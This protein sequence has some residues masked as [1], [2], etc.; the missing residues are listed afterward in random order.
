MARRGDNEM[1]VNPF[2]DEAPPPAVAERD[3]LMG[4][5]ASAPAI[6]TMG[7]IGETTWRNFICRSSHPFAAFF[8][9]IFK[10]AAIVL[11]VCGSTLGLDYVTI[12]VCCVLL[13]AFDFWT[14]KNVTGR[15][16]VGLRWWIRIK[17]DGSNEWLFESA[18]SNNIPQL[19]AR[20]FWWALY[21]TPLTWALLCLLSGWTIGWLLVNAVGVALTGANAWGYMK[22]SSDAQRRL[23]GA[24]ASGALSAAAYIPGALPAIG[25]TVMS[26]LSNPAPAAASRSAQGQQQQQSAGATAPAV[27]AVSI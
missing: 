11:Y 2:T 1:T 24:L 3:S 5:M 10:A 4:S 7:Q 18:P 23:Q 16:L 26:V 6:G 9:L 27:D 20:I 17:E 21:L 22:C 12:F 25:S 14:V 19:D 15:L 13:H 8:H